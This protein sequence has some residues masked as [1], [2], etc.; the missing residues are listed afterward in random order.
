M[1][2]R[3]LAIAAGVSA[4]ITTMAPPFAAQER[5]DADINAKIRKEGMDNSKIMRVLHYLTDVY[6]PRLTGSPNLKAAGE[7]VIKETASWGFTNGHLEPWD[8]GKPGWTNDFGSV[9]VTSPFKAKLEFEVL[10]W[11]PGTNGAVKAKAFNLIP[12][13][14]PT[15]EELEGYLASVGAQVQNA[16]VFV[17]KARVVPVNLNPPAKRRPDDQVR[18]QYDPNAPPG[19]GRRGGRGG[20][21][22]GG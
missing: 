21:G 5:I 1:K 11:T 20:R 4:V 2:Y 19:E 3:S 7:W 12:P 10:A 6:G 18:Q 22:G 16:A 8:W 13:D 17:G 15:K 9:A 14:Q